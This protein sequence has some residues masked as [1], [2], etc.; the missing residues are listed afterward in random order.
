MRR[1]FV[2]L[3]VLLLAF[4]AFGVVAQEEAVM[5][6]LV[7]YG[8][9]LPAGYGMLSVEDLN[10]AL[11]EQE[12][13]LLDV[14][15]VGEYAEGHI[16]GAFNVPVRTVA[17]NLNLLPDLD[18][19]IVVICKGGSRALLGA[20][21]LQVLGY[22][23]VR[24]LRGGFDAWVGEEL[25]VSLE[26]FMVEAG[27]AP[28]FDPALLAAVDNFLSTLPEG[29]ALVSAA[30][31]AAELVENPPILIDVRSDDEWAQG[32]IEGAQHIWINEFMARVSELPADK[33]ANIV[34]YCQSGVR[35]AIGMALMRIMGYTNV[36][37]MSGGVNAWNN[38][39]LPLVGVPEVAAPEFDLNAYL[40]AYVAALPETFNAVRVPDLAT[41]L[42]AEND[43]LLVD[44]RTTDEFAEGFIAGAIN[45]PLNELT[46]HLDLLPNLDQPMVIYC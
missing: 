15:E 18:A 14:R 6:R 42:A 46:Q 20:T 13:V 17:Q 12:I 1:L 8:A 31:L 21:A 39:Q 22:T 27:T 11:V 43:L 9:N 24:V 32:Y 26:P 35:G 28:E 45:I 19:P 5:E 16:E 3:A 25:P 41:E 36:R 23:N 34:I 7:E 33:D 38:A 40:A 30:N 37:N 2:L 29:Y 4:T 10:A 44:V